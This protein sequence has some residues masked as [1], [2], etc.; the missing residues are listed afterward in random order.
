MI[1]RYLSGSTVPAYAPIFEEGADPIPAADL[2]GKPFWVP[3]GDLKAVFFVRTFSGNPDYDPPKS[4]G[5]LPRLPSGHLVQLDFSDGERIFGDVAERAMDPSPRLL[6]HRARPR[7]QQ[8]PPL[9]EPR[10]PLR[11]SLPPG[12]PAVTA[13]APPKPFSRHNLAKAGLIGTAA[14]HVESLGE[15]G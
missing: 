2:E 7:G 12:G 9:R 1:L 14:L 15:S 4:A 6:R 11:P 13:A 8:H 10:Q 3:L 5:D